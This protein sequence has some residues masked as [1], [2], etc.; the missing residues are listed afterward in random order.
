LNR[1]VYSAFSDF[2][3]S[4]DN[5]YIPA[6]QKL[7]FLSFILLGFWKQHSSGR[8]RGGERKTAE[9]KISDLLKQKVGYDKFPS[10]GFLQ[11][12]YPIIFK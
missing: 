2:E 10:I 12:H 3:Y 11:G 1:G 5:P 7:N 8:V 9:R 4:F 6:F